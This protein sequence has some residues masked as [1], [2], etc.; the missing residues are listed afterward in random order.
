MSVGQRKHAVSTLRTKKKD[1]TWSTQR[2][3]H[4]T[5]VFLCFIQ[6]MDFLSFHHLFGPWAIIIREMMKDLVLFLLMLVIFLFGFTFQLAAVYLPVTAGADILAWKSS[7][8]VW[9]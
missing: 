2:V 3:A 7:P 5:A 6:L 8:S 9:C 1:W 4:L